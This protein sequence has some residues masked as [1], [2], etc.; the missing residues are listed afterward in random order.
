M[1]L[2]DQDIRY[3]AKKLSLPKK[4]VEKITEEESDANLVLEQVS[5]HPLKKEDLS[6]ITLLTYIKLLVYRYSSDTKFDINQKLYVSKCI[7]YHYNAIRKCLDYQL[8][9]QKGFNEQKSQYL[10]VLVGLFHDIMPPAMF[11]NV[12]YII[13]EGFRN[14]EETRDIARNIEIWVEIL[15]EIKKKGYLD[16]PVKL[17]PKKIKPKPR[18]LLTN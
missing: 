4:I 2:N 15:K 6:N 10:L 9:T 8:V 5:T 14:R 3:V 17:S 18:L 13:G 7:Y 12:N 16:I 11:K 1:P